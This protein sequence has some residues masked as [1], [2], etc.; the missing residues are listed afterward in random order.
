MAQLSA[1]PVPPFAGPRSDASAE[2]EPFRI[3]SDECLRQDNKPGAS[4]GG[5]AGK[6]SELIDG[7]VWIEGDRCGLD[8]GG[9]EDLHFSSPVG[10]EGSGVSDECSKLELV[11]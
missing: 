10:F 4:T 6:G 3:A 9:T 11:T 8:N 1:K 5:L 7:A 2:V